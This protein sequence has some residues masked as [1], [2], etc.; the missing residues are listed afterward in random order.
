M[1]TSLLI[2]ATAIE[3]VGIAT[4]GIGLGY[5]IAHGGDLGYVLI[6]TGSVLVAAGGVLFGKFIRG[7]R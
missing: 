3:L 6:T 1:K 2:A 4:I 5:E 7:R